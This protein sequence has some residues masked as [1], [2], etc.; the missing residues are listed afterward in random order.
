MQA[1]QIKI[2]TC[3]DKNLYSSLAQGSHCSWE[4]ERKIFFF[5][6]GNSHSNTL[7]LVFGFIVA[8]SV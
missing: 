1:Q 6:L 8:Q 4:N 2:F 7:S 3:S 5:L